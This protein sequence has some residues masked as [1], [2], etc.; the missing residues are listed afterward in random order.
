MIK[1]SASKTLQR[2]LSAFLLLAVLLTLL[3]SP[4][5][6]V[7]AASFMV[8][9]IDDSG[10]GSLRQAILD[11]NSS[12]G[13]DT[14]TFASEVSGGTIT[15]ASTLPAVTDPSGL[16]ID[17]TGQNITLSGNN[18]FT[19]L[20]VNGGSLIIEGLTITKAAFGGRHPSGALINNSGS[21]TT[22]IGS[23]LSNNQVS[24]IENYGTLTIKDN[25][26]ITGNITGAFGGGIFNFL[27][28][29]VTITDSTIYGNTAY[30][31]GGVYNELD[32]KMTIIRSVIELNHATSRGGGIRNRGELIIMDSLFQKNTAVHDGGGIVAFLAKGA[33]MT[34]TN[35]TFSENVASNGGA[36]N[37]EYPTTITNSTFS[38]NTAANGG[39]IYNFASIYSDDTTTGAMT[40]VSTTFVNNTISNNNN[41]DLT[42]MNSIV[43]GADCSGTITD[44]LGNLSTGSGC[45][46][47]SIVTLD[48][49]KLG[50]L[51][52]NAPG[53][54][55]THALLP[56]SFA[57]DTA[58]GDCPLTDQRGV[59]RP[60]G[61]ACDVGAFELEQDDIGPVFGGFEAPLNG[62]MV[63]QVKAGQG[64]PVRFSLDGD[65]GLEIFTESYP[66]FEAAVC[67]SGDPTEPVEE[68]VTNSK[69]GLTY[70]AETG[71]YT[72]VWKTDKKLAG[73]CGSL[74]L[75]FTDGSQYP[76][77]FSFTK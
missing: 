60:Q 27:G 64:I 5:P 21:T 77:K 9:N 76:V 52:L 33:S 70:D 40:V 37:S 43:A 17:G 10:A 66:K 59:V 47:A 4:V 45:P 3:W 30:D 69:S 29:T 39:A 51:A 58:V 26:Q 35:S 48:D 65:F 36:I 11:A 16:T 73:R 63:N 1:Q 23:T 68:T 50:L 62:D 72:Y 19:V 49:L 42:L 57:I 14:I 74:V 7:Q 56:G 13:A 38:G 54:T 31:G 55:P 20:I 75:M 25:T 41:G 24:A 46:S 15:L 2:L 6:A 18:A 22:I 32:S 44:G 71:L 28:G 53:T 8:T 34:I 12:D 67:T 61:A